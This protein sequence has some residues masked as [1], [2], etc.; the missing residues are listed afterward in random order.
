MTVLYPT[1]AAPERHPE[2]VTAL[3][4][5]ASAASQWALAGHAGFR[6]PESV[7]GLSPRQVREEYSTTAAVQLGI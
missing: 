1:A 3:R 2:W 7:L 5:P 4:C 6:N